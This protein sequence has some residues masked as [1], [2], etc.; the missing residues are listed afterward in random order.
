[1]FKICLGIFEYET[2]WIVI[3]VLYWLRFEGV[4]LSQLVIKKMKS[5]SYKKYLYEIMIKL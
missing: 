1:M 3:L 2:V 4:I 5:I